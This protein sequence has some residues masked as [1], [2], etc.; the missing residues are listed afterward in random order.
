[1]IEYHLHDVKN[2]LMLVHGNLVR[3]GKDHPEINFQ[4]V[5]TNLNR[6]NEL[7]NLAYS[8]LSHSLELNLTMIKVA[9]FKNLVRSN[10]EKIKKMYSIEIED[11]YSDFL[12]TKKSCIAVELTLLNQILDN[13]FDNS[14]KAKGQ[15]MIV[16]LVAIPN[17]IILELID[18]GKDEA[19]E[20]SHFEILSHLPNGIGS[21]L[22]AEHMETMAGK[23]TW[24]KR[25]DSNGMVVRLSFPEIHE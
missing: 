22:I 19:K 21:K 25:M 20:I 2:K 18:N 1:M 8:H 13:I 9:D 17:Q 15:K 7:I 6:V 23:V 12:L 4:P 14:M 5:F 24:A 3:I 10:M 11:Q 16:R